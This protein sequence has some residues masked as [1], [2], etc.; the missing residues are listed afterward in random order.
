VY[1][2]SFKSMHQLHTELCVFMC[3][4]GVANFRKRCIYN[5]IFFGKKLFLNFKKA[6]IMTSFLMMLKM[7]SL[8]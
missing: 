2:I 3:A 4:R 5:L 1:D 7:S 8:F 6:V